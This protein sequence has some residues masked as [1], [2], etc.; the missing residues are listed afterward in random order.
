MRVILYVCLCILIRVYSLAHLRKGPY[1]IPIASPYKEFWPPCQDGCFCKLEV[2]LLGIMITG[3]LLFGFFIGAD[4]HV[5]C[6]LYRILHT[7]LRPPDCKKHP[8]SFFRETPEGL[9]ALPNSLPPQIG[10]LAWHGGCARVRK[11]K[12]SLDVNLER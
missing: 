1:I 3:A 2:L 7:I 5:P 9:R 10:F 12:H 6:I 11:P 8:D 4:F